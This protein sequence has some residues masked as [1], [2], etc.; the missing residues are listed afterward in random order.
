MTRSMLDTPPGALGTIDD[1][2]WR[3]VSDFGLPGPDRGRGGKYLL[4]PPDYKGQLP[5]GG[6]FM[7]YPKTIRVGLLGR[8]FMENNDPKP[9]V[10]TVRKLTKV[11]P[12]EVGG[13]GT[14]IA[15]FLA[16]DAKLGRPTEPPP[17]KIHDGTGLAIN[18]MPPNDWSFY[19]V[20]NELVQQEPATVLDPE[21]MGSIAAIGIVKGKAFAPDART[22]K[23][24][25]EALALAN[26]TSR[27]LFMNPRDKS[28]FLYPNSAW[29]NMLF[30]TGSEFETP[31]PEITREGAKPFPPTGYRTLDAR[32]AFFYYITGISPAMAMRL[33]GV[34]SQY[35][36]AT[37]D[38]DKNYLDGGKT[39]KVMLPRVFPQR[40]SGPSRST[41][42]RPVRCSTRHSAIRGPAAR[43]IRHLRP[44][45]ILTERPL[46][47]SDRRN[48]MASSAVTGS[49]RCPAGAFSSCSASTARSNRSLPRSGARARSS[50]LSESH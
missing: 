25:T 2:W 6:F 14:S 39:Y 24:L 32:T 22:K 33:T 50:W 47:T 37:V 35:C 23:V 7:V 17:L 28:W 8:A 15:E 12:Y 42:P 31:I 10:E 41:T 29:Q 44:S 26:A 34:G 9:T 46:C 30:A 21:L 48:P 20:L 11:Y 3:W 40:D 43:A 5:E 4:V 16:G 27:S 18:T 13:I 1:M 38:A 45:R 19:E 36:W 49:R